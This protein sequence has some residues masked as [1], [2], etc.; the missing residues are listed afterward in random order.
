MCLEE[1]S[2]ES[3]GSAESVIEIELKYGE[4]LELKINELGFD[5]RL[6]LG[7]RP[8]ACCCSLGLPRC[9]V[10]CLLCLLSF[11]GQLCFQ[12]LSSCHWCSILRLAC[13]ILIFW[14]SP[15]L[16]H[17][18][19]AL[20]TGDGLDPMP[21]LM[22]KLLEQLVGPLHVLNLTS[23]I[24]AQRGQNQ[25]IKLRECNFLLIQMEDIMSYCLHLFRI[26][27]PE[28]RHPWLAMMLITEFIHEANRFHDKLALSLRTQAALEPIY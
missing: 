26:W 9:L 4:H 24:H 20:I 8:H 2:N 11:L 27:Q 19:V 22:I 25:M 6:D 28:L 18:L 13:C 16:W 10:G 21:I 5:L 12:A 7:E 23:Q 15:T 1:H 14:L 17:P 3:K